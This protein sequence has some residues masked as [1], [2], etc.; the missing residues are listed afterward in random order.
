MKVKSEVKN[1]VD[2]KKAKKKTE[3][4]NFKSIQHAAASIRKYILS[5]IHSGK[6]KKH[7]EK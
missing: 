6:T 3:Q 1:K 2:F 4:A 5:T 7:K